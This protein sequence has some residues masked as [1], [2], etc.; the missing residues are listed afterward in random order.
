MKNNKSVGGLFKG[1]SKLFAPATDPRQQFA[2]VYE[3]QL[4][5]ISGID[6]RIVDVNAQLER[7]QSAHA[8]FSGA[9]SQAETRVVHA[10]RKGEDDLARA[11]L[12]K[13]HMLQERI[14]ANQQIEAGLVQKLEALQ[15]FRTRLLTEI[16]SY[17]AAEDS[18][19][20]QRQLA[21]VQARNAVNLGEITDK[22]NQLQSELVA[23]EDSAS[24]VQEDVQHGLSVPP[25]VSE[26]IEQELAT[27]KQKLAS[28][29]PSE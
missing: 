11:L 28:E 19:A 18:L 16:E 7:V 9:D 3:E 23:A 26:E 20:A 21:A 4:A 14:K 8:N 29:P 1:I 13:R 2:S 25:P 12:G 15:A 10:L 24:R 22:L 27:L 17:L 5:Q 6:K